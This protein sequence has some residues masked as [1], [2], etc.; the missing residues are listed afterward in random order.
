M[1]SL[2]D[3]VKAFVLSKY[4]LKQLGLV[5]LFYLSIVFIMMLYL[6]FSTQHGERIE[7][8]NLIGKS[9]DQGRLMLEDIG[10]E[11]QIMDSVYD[12]KKPSGTILSQ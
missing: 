3:Q 8:P 9:S 11:Y 1:K 6:R 7:V 2:F 4:F 5:V 10:L 12:P